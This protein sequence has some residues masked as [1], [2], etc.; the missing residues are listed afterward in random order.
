MDIIISDAT[1]K[2]LNKEIQMLQNEPIELLDSYPDEKNCLIWYF[3]L[4]GPPDTSYQGGYY[5]GKLLYP[6]DYPARAPDYIMLTPSGRFEIDKKICL[7]NSGYHSES[8]SPIWNIATL[9]V[10]F[11]SI[12][13]DD[14]TSGISHI[15]RSADERKLLAQDS[16]NF[17]M[18]HHRKILEGFR[19]FVVTD[20][21]GNIR[22]KTDAELDAEQKEKALFAKQ[23]R[24]R[25]DKK[26]ADKKLAKEQ[27]ETKVEPVAETK[28]EPVAETKVEPVAEV[29]P[30]KPKRKTKK[31][32]VDKDAEEVEVAEPK[33]G[34]KKIIKAKAVID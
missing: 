25:K 32:L 7:T 12:M 4:K 26:K 9:L 16:F 10:G 31:Q 14:S 28:V 15:K 19:R 24:E 5:M 11:V 8:W 29:V 17:N 34:R 2:R 30:E 33:K 3:M 13:A 22:M 1:R 21:N 23:E 18:T 27:K 6:A 20:D